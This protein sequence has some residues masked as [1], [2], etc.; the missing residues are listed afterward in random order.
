M[1]REVLPEAAEVLEIGAGTGQHAE[2]FTGAMPDWRWWPTN[3][4]DQLDTLAAG[5]AGFERPNLGTPAALDV[6]SA[7]PERHYDA[8][9]SANT[10]HILA[11]SGVR[12]LFNG[13]ARV[14]DGHGH[15]VLYG[16]FRRAGQHTSESNARFEASLRARDTA[17]GIRDLA[18]IDRW[19][20]AAGLVRIA[21]LEM[22]A[23][24]LTL[25]FERESDSDES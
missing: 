2:F 15:F 17:M 25:V 18:D 1:L 14:L 4:P 19:A 12:A 5:L 8:V 23:N 20:A 24:N 3:A 22:P 21:E 16:P 7:W 6:F 11:E 9:V 13:A 10:A